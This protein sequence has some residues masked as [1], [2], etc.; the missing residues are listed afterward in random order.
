MRV[1][2]YMRRTGMRTGAALAA[3][4]ALLVTAG[5]SSSGKSSSASSAGSASGTVSQASAGALASCAG[6]IA[7][8]SPI[9]FG[10]LNA[11]TGASSSQAGTFAAAVQ[12]RIQYQNDKFGGVAGHKIKVDV[13]DS[14]S[15]V[16]QVLPAL[17]TLQGSNP[18][19]ILDGLSAS[20]PIFP[21][22]KQNGIPVIAGAPT[23]PAFGS[24]P[25]AFSMAGAY[26]A[27]QV[28]TSSLEYLKSIG[29]TKIAAFGH[30]VTSSLLY[31][32]TVQKLAP[33]FG[34]TVVYTRL[35][36]PLTAYDATNDALQMK[37][38]G[39]DGIYFGTALDPAVSIYTAALQQGL[40]FKPGAVEGASL[41]DA[42]TV[43]TGK[44]DGTAGQT[45]S[46]PF[47]GDASSLSTSAQLFRTQLD[48]YYPNTKLQLYTMIGWVV[49]D[50]AIAVAEGSQGCFT[51]AQF[52]KTGRAIT[53]YNADGFLASTLSFTPGQTPDGS[54]ANCN[55]FSVATNKA[56]VSATKTVCG[57]VSTLP[58]S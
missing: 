52:I 4:V 23:D 41:Y 5:C 49:A 3:T 9:D 57:S 12:A 10:V 53:N 46:V 37:K 44:I 47:L 17:K 15:D 6:N 55:Y 8:G 20:G 13:Q 24:D 7:A 22:L 39:V 19:A 50:F 45:Y 36:V 54:V 26:S 25:N 56:F 33:Q 35:D 32:Q 2:T 51:Q 38:D 48:K 34:M 43:A 29:V 31:T 40:T 18:L 30:N 11:T 28:S 42:A 14:A 58:G 21:Y 1:E 27:T 16:T